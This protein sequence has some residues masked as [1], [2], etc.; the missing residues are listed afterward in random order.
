[1]NVVLAVQKAGYIKQA[2]HTQ[3]TSNDAK[4]IYFTPQKVGMS[5]AVTPTWDDNCN[6]FNPKLLHF[7]SSNID[8]TVWHASGCVQGTV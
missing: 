2:M 8:N 6:S 1:M 5:V 4:P 3:L 7:S